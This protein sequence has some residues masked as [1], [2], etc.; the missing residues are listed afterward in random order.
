MHALILAAFAA[1]F[2]SEELGAPFF[3]QHTHLAP[4][5]SIVLTTG[6]LGVLWLFAAAQMHALNHDGRAQRV[7]AVESLASVMR[8]VLLAVHAGAACLGLL[9]AIRSVV[10][11][12]IA[13]DELLALMPFVLGLCGIEFIVYPVQRR[14]R[15][16]L[17]IRSL[18]L[19]L[20]VHPYPPRVRF[21]WLWMRHH[22]LFLLVPLTLLLAWAESCER[23][24]SRFGF[25]DSSDAE[26]LQLG[27]QVIGLIAVFALIPPVLVRIWDTVPLRSG[28]LRDRL[29]ALA[30]GHGVGVRDFLVWRT[31]GLMLNGAA[32]GLIRP[33]RYV[34]LTDGL[35]DR[36]GADEVEAVAAHEIGHIRHRHT[37]WLAASVLGSVLVFGTLAGWLTSLFD[38]G[39]SGGR[40]AFG[41]GVLATLGMTLTVLGMVSRRFERQADAFAARHLSGERRGSPPVEVSAWAA[42]AMASALTVVAEAHDIIVDRPTFRHGSIERRIRTLAEAVGRR[43]DQLPA[44]RSARRAQRAVLALLVAGCAMVTIDV[45][46]GMGG[47]G[48]AH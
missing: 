18:D 40:I 17:T 4:V 26:A 37:P 3:P 44:D 10:G 39:T 6:A 27:A 13:G 41:V 8:W 16:A 23:A 1:L 19:G 7:R 46:L 43:S 28:P 38:P 2:V 34:V 31:S 20:A 15:D 45:L 29:D 42:H 36:L 9:D 33:L 22:V 32:I 47:L 25:R 48:V 5:V 30:R 14:L 12:V 11:D 24:I 21:V 35:L